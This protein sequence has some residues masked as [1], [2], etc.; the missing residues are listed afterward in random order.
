M[1]CRFPALQFRFKRKQLAIII[2][3][4][5]VNFAFH[6]VELTCQDQFSERVVTAAKNTLQLLHKLAFQLKHRFF[7]ELVNFFLVSGSEGILSGDFQHNYHY[8]YYYNY[9]QYI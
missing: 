6:V 5:N 1:N 4:N 3:G 2:R 7:Y 9:S 8:S